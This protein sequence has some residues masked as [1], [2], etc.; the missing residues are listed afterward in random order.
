MA[1][2]EPA[3]PPAQP[4]CFQR[5]ALKGGQDD[6][7]GA[8]PLLDIFLLWCL[9]SF[10]RAFPKPSPIFNGKSTQMVEPQSHRDLGNLL[11]RLGASQ[12]LPNLLESRHSDVAH[13]RYASIIFEVFEEGASGDPRC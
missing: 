13:R 7:L 4:C 12:D 5:A 8:D 11:L 3:N 1:R 2:D 9:K 10:R 6:N